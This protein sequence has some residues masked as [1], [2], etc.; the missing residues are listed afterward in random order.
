VKSAGAERRRIGGTAVSGLLIYLVLIF[1]ALAMVLPFIH[2]LAKSFSYPSEVDAGRVSLWPRKITLGNYYYY[3]RKHLIPLSRSF[4]ITIYITGFGTLW[5]IYMTALMAYPLSR[6]KREF[7][8]GPFAMGIAIFSIIMFPPIIPYFLAIRSY[9]LMDTLWSIILTHT[10]VPFHLILL[11]TFFRQ[12]PEDLFDSCRIDG[13]SDWRIFF[14]I[15]LPLSKAA[16]ATVA[17][18]TAIILW[19]IFLHPLLFITNPKKF[20]LQIF[21][22]SIFQEGGADPEVLLQRDPFDNTESI[23]SALVILTILPIVLIY[24]LLQKHFIKGI[25]LGALKE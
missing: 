18:F 24:P 6:S 9:G 1:I 3:Y 4:G 17:I 2:E 22:R 7:R 14:Q 19:N 23:K 15:V 21:L 11:V 5:S 16:L 25:M 10:V 12:L 20:P 8:L 13:G